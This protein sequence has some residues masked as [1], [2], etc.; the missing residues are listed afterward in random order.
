MVMAPSQAKG[1][2]RGLLVRGVVVQGHLTATE[3]GGR[4]NLVLGKTVDRVALKAFSLVAQQIHGHRHALA[5]DRVRL[6]L[7]KKKSSGG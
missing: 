6:A 5:C 4:K 7:G 3:Q 1:I 2:C